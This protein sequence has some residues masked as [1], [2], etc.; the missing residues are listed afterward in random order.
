M[1][2]RPSIIDTAHSKVVASC[3]C[4]GSVAAD[5]AGSATNEH[6]AFGHADAPWIFWAAATAKKSVARLSS[7]TRAHA[8]RGS[9]P[10][11][12]AV[13]FSVRFGSGL[14]AWKDDPYRRI[15]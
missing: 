6:F 2:R 13:A 8:A 14:D 12:E 10:A 7:S 4:L 15:G 11:A 1:K 3:E 9:G 5:E